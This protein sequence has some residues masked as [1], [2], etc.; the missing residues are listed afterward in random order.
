[1]AVEIKMPQLSDTMHS[2][3]IL[4]WKKKE[5]DKISRGDILAEVETEKA[6]LEIESFHQGTLIKILVPAN[7]QAGVGDVIAV[8]G[9]AGEVVG[10]SAPVAPAVS[11]SAPSSSSPSSSSLGNS[12]PVAAPSSPS[13]AKPAPQLIPN[14]PTSASMASAPKAPSAPASFGVSPFGTPPSASHS[15][16]ATQWGSA[17]ISS[18][19]GRIKASPLAKKIAAE[20]NVDLTLIRGTGPEGRIVRK[21][22]EQMASHS[23]PRSAPSASTS[24]PASRPAGGSTRE[25]SKMRA[26]IASRMQESVREAPHFYVTTKVNMGEAKRLQATLKQ[27]PEFAGLSLNH[28][29]I[30]AAAYALAREPRVNNAVRNGA[31]FEPG[32][33]NIGII[34]SVEDGLLIPVIREADRLSLG[35]ISRE[36]KAAV[37]RAKAGKPTSADLSGGTFSI[38]NMGMFDVENFTAIINPGQGAVLAVS[39]TITEPIVVKGQIVVGETMKVTL[40]VDHRIIDG[41]MGA[42]FLKHFKESLEMPAL[43]AF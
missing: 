31:I 41:V 3:K 32:Q 34:T 2:G 25:M 39:S 7:S 37:E 35:E 21:D 12:S 38:S 23:A 33:I 9:E 14:F 28:L 42:T 30:K 36:A 5:G 8:L 24:T 27:R 10:A 6:N 11:S 43:L 18:P 16:S 13:M 29:I 26:L 40:S 17:A 15:A 1:M 19:G 20:Q 4:S 22:V